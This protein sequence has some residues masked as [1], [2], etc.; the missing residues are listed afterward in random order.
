MSG[1]V[2]ARWDQSDPTGSV[3]VSLHQSHNLASAHHRVACPVEALIALPNAPIAQ[4]LAKQIKATS[5]GLPKDQG[6]LGPPHLHVGIAGPY[7]RF[8]DGADGA[9][10]RKFAQAFS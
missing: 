6:H 3:R 4:Q 8:L 9:L 5:P 10:S 1:I 2:G 7:L